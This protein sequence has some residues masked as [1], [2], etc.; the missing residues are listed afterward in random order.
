M[1]VYYLEIFHPDGQPFKTNLEQVTEKKI[2]LQK[3]EIASQKAEI[4]NQKLEKEREEKL[5]LLQK[6]RE[7]GVDTDEILGK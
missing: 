7:L 1:I 2:A 5:L 6:L 4:A 3:A